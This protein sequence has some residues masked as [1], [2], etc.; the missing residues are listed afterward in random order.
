M[1]NRREQV[2]YYAGWFDAN[3][4]TSSEKI[5]LLCQYAKIIH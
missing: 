1:F 3:V 4:G 5:D 2:L